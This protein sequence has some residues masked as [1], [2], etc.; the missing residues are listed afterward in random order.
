MAP[1]VAVGAKVARPLILSILAKKLGP[2]ASKALA[3]KS[4]DAM[5]AGKDGLSAALKLAS[6]GAGGAAKIG[7]VVT[8]ALSAVGAFGLGLGG[9]ALQ[10]AGVAG[11]ALA[12]T[13]GNIPRALSVTPDAK[14]A[15][16]GRTPMDVVGDIAS[17]VGSAA[18]VGISMAGNALGSSFND[19]A[20]ALRL[21]QLEDRKKAEWLAMMNAIQQQNMRPSDAVLAGRMISNM[22]RVQ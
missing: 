19:A 12:Q 2:A 5:I 8:D 1:I 13:A 10:T 15:Y 20:N 3:G 7:G 6:K 11:G 18:N 4:L 22:G 16:Y 9:K 14:K 17:G 21:R